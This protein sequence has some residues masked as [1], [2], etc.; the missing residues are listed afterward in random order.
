L[1]KK[2]LINSNFQN[3]KL[4]KDLPKDHIFGKPI[5]YKDHN[6]QGV[7]TGSYLDNK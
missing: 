7:M 1:N 5:D 4:A 6:M 2:L 3:F